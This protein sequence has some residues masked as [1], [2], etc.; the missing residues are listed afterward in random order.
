MPTRLTHLLV[1]GQLLCLG[2]HSLATS[3]LAHRQAGCSTALH[4]QGCVVA[5]P[6]SDM[7]SRQQGTKPVTQG[8]PE[9]HPCLDLPFAQKSLLPCCSICLSFRLDERSSDPKA[10]SHPAGC[11][12]TSTDRCNSGLLPNKRVTPQQLPQLALLLPFEPFPDIHV[13]IH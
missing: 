9:R 12:H 6:G 2:D 4:M 1:G 5:D 10:L 3:R 7:Q 13:V 8:D 11:S